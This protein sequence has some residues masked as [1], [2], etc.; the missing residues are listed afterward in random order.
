MPKQ[1]SVYAKTR[2]E[3][4]EKLRKA[5]A[6]AANGIVF[7]AGPVTIG[8]YLEHW[9][10]NSVWPLVQAEKLEYSTY[11][12]YAGNVRNHLNPLLGHKKLKDLNRA[13]VRALYNAKGKELGSRSVDYLH[14]T[15]QMA[16]KR[17]VR[18]DLVPRNVAEGERPRSSRSREEAKAFSANQVKVL[19]EEA[20]GERNHALYVV[21]VHTGLR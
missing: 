11:I 20:R 9:L 4:A 10:T 6:D 3:V 15:L 8:E 2:A 21:A 7:D 18:D 1:K 14:V 12:R 19:L 13:E 5:M 16:L 17:A